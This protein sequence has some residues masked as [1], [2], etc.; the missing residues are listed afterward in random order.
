MGRGSASTAFQ[1]DNAD[2]EFIV[3]T[4]RKKRRKGLSD[5]TSTPAAGPDGSRGIACDRA[6]RNSKHVDPAGRRANPAVGS[7]MV[8]EGISGS[9]AMRVG[10]E[11]E[12]AATSASRAPDHAGEGGTGVRLAPSATLGLAVA[13]VTAASSRRARSVCSCRQRSPPLS[14]RSELRREIGP[15]GVDFCR[16]TLR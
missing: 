10:R 9:T 7:R 4:P 13:A 11:R 16:A 6:A 8:M 3:R 1:S 12:P 2:H 5:W 15:G 14:E